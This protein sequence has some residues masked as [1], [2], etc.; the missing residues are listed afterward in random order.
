MARGAK[1]NEPKS[2]DDYL[3]GA[4]DKRRALE[5]LRKDIKA[6]APKAGEC[7][8][9]GIPDFRLNGR[10]LLSYEAAAREEH[11]QAI[12]RCNHAS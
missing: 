11:P 10:L 1:P 7:I 9:D 3:A 8:S 5:K 2:H 4:S 12:P 6:V